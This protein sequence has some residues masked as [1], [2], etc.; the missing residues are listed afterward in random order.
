MTLK[1]A[2]LIALMLIA[3]LLIVIGKLHD[4]IEGNHS[5]ALFDYVLASI[6]IASVYVE[7]IGRE[8]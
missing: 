5:A 1:T 4:D 8:R 7:I 6:I 3:F 2:I